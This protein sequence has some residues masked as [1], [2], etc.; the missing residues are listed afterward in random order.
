MNVAQAM[1]IEKVLLLNRIVYIL[2]IAYHVAVLPC[3][4]QALTGRRAKVTA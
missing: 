2:Y 3:M 1:T 4:R